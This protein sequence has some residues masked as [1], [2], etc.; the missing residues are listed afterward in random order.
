LKI[1]DCPPAARKRD[2]RLKRDDAF[3]KEV[4][5]KKIDWRTA[6]GINREREITIVQTSTKYGSSSLF[7]PN[8]EEEAYLV[9]T[10][11]GAETGR[12]NSTSA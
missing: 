3:S 7:K 9:Q 1:G 12:L 5:D 2:G 11:R 4:Q 8:R 6:A 10:T